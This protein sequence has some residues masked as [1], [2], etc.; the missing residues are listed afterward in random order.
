MP[1]NPV[2]VTVPGAWH[3]GWVWYPV[4][5]RLRSAGHRVLTLTMPGL[6][7][8]DEPDGLAL[9]D[10]I[11]HVVNEGL[12][13]GGPVNLVAH[14]WGGI[15]A[16]AAAHILRDQVK[17]LIYV[18]AFVPTPGTALNDENPPEVA[19]FMREA[20]AASPHHTVELPFDIF[21][22]VL[23]QDQTEPVQ[24]LV[25]NL[26]TAM[27]G[28]YMLDAPQMPPTSDLVMPT[29]YILAENDHGLPRPGSH[30]AARLGVQPIMVP[31][32]HESLLTHPD[33]VAGAILSV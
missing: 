9:Q 8:G 16:T 26:L 15:P 21:A 18:S 7:D 31:G 32:S 10:A 1:S 12:R 19:A 25:H 3:G 6:N 4:A 33:E 23:M 13:C 2:F 22:A 11:D 5:Q 17:Q 24:R 20:I 28:R 30:L 14:S 27:P 29:A